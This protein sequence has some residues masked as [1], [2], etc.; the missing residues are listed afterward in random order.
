M[1]TY[2]SFVWWPKTE[3][4]TACKDLSKVQR[5]ACL[6]ITGAKRSAPTVA[7]NA[8]LNLPP[9]QTYVKEEAIH[10]ARRI[11]A[12]YDFKPGDYIT[13]H[14][15]IFNEFSFLT[16]WKLVGDKLPDTHNN[17]LPFEIKI[18]E[19]RDWIDGEINFEEEALVYYTDGS[20]KEEMVGIGVY[21]PGYRYYEALG[22]TPTI[23]QAEVYAIMKCATLCLRRGDIRGKRIYIAS[24]SQAAVRALGAYVLKSKLV[25]EC[26]E[27]LQELALNNDLTIMWVPGHE[28]I[29]G[30]ETADALARKGSE[31][32]FI[33]PEPSKFATS[34]KGSRNG[35]REKR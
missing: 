21:G 8:M 14:M 35:R 34:R 19:R 20:R 30:N 2:A 15:R 11:Q 29:V 7:L 16:E 18:P 28:G 33:G 27:L 17:V 1:V 31:N 23:F 13:G 12:N 4:Q 25:H 32:K 9:L 22:S 3:Y 5:L 26:L 6:S 10:S 24:D